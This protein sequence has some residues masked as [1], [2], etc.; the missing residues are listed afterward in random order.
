MYL[1]RDEDLLELGYDS[2]R[3]GRATAIILGSV[4]MLAL[5]LGFEGE[6]VKLIA[7]SM[8]GSLHKTISSFI[9]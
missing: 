8:I 4:S 9:F 6:R 3:R 5:V 2:K 7:I 1:T